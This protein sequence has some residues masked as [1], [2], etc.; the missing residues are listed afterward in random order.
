MTGLYTNQ[1]LKLRKIP[2]EKTRSMFSALYVAWLSDLDACPA[3]NF[4]KPIP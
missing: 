4:I 2:H 1:A 3:L